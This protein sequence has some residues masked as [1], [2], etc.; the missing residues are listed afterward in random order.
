MKRFLTVLVLIAVAAST[1][2]AAAAPQ[3]VLRLGE[4]HVADYPTTRGDMEFSRLVEERTGGRIRIEV[5]HSKQL[6]EEKAVI[7]QVQFGAIDFTRVSISPLAAFAPAF[8]ALQMPY[9]YR[10][11]EH[12]WKV[13]NGPIGEEFLNSLEPAN[14]VGLCWYDSGA[15]NFYNSRREIKSV[16][17]LKGLKIRVQESKLM[18][19]LVSALGAV[20]T[21]MPFGE[22]YSALQTGVI[23]G[24]E[25]NWPSY[26]STSHYEVAK[27]F[28]LDGHTRVPEI[29]IASKMTMDKLSKEDQDIIR[30]AAKDS[31]PY[32]IKLWKEYEKV[33]EEKVTAAGSIITHLSPEAVS[34]FQKAMEPLYSELKPELQEVVKKIREVQ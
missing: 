19:G 26:F 18:M 14:F 4:T 32:Q 2:P 13:L 11:E 1:L 21:P 5:Y 28:T 33:S 31:M 25:N 20:P 23:D 24:A 9:L 12:M 10:D 6:G 17:D 29:L 22:V 8:D 7:E 30:Q 27:Y 3:M 34:A 15:R 16:A